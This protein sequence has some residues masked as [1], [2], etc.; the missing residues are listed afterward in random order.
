MSLRPASS[1]DTDTVWGRSCLLSHCHSR[2]HHH[3]VAQ[4]ASL[5]AFGLSSNW[6]RRCS[7]PSGHKVHT[8]KMA[9]LDDDDRFYVCYYWILYINMWLAS[10]SILYHISCFTEVLWV[11]LAVD[12]VHVV[13]SQQEEVK[14]KC[15]L[16]K[17]QRLLWKCVHHL[18]FYCLTSVFPFSFLVLLLVHCWSL[19]LLTWYESFPS[20]SITVIWRHGATLLLL[21]QFE[22]FRPPWVFL[23]SFY[24]LM[25]KS[26]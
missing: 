9:D 16:P 24:V 20:L 14:K 25:S 1:T 17:D 8:T 21:L 4:A 18:C 12:L 3:Y 11:A 23:P 10:G 6:W 26:Y 2:C 13:M 7:E 22:V 19:R 5:S 15:P